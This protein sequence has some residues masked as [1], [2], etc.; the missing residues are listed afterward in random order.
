MLNNIFDLNKINLDATIFRLRFFQCNKI[1]P[2]RKYFTDDT[3]IYPVIYS[4]C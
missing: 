2:Y 4:I 3:I 1:K